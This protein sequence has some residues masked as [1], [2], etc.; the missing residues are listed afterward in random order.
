VQYQLVV[1]TISAGHLK[2]VSASF[3]VTDKLKIRTGDANHLLFGAP[4]LLRKLP[5]IAAQNYK[6]VFR[7]HVSST[8]LDGPRRNGMDTFASIV[9]QPRSS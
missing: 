9:L 2:Y 4:S 7:R 8:R 6:T 5:V 1:E 3:D